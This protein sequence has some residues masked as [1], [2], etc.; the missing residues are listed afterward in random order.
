MS[1]RREWENIKSE[2]VSSSRARKRTDTL[3]FPL[4]F[5]DF[6]PKMKRER[7]YYSLTFLLIA[8]FFDAKL[9]NFDHSY[10]S[11]NLFTDL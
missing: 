3:S 5:V 1:T 9:D 4:H 6:T 7:E 2:N 8:F 11:L 10:R